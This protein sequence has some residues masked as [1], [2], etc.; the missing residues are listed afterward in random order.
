MATY[1][2][3]A[4][5]AIFLSVVVSMLIP[6]GKLNKTV[7]FV[8]RMVCIYVLIQPV[9]ALFDIPSADSVAGAADYEYVCNAYSKHQSRQMELLIFEKFS[10]EA[11]CAVKVGYEDG[12]FRV[13][14][15]DIGLVQKNEQL[16]DD[17]YAY[18]DGLG[19]INI[20][21]YAESD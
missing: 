21:V 14:G 9:T 12:E 4:A 1:L 17:I 6:D 15:V 8:M 5:S 19:Y 18:L 16:I 20:S 7:T 2:A 13:I 3:G 11:D 10:A